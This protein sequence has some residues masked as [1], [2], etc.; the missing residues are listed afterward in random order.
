MSK[1]IGTLPNQVPSNADLGSAA[2]KQVEE[3]LSA[4]GS[5]LSAIDSTILRTA[6]DFFIYN[7]ANDSDGGEWRK[8]CQDKSWYKRAGE[9]GWLGD[10][11][12]RPDFPSVAILI[13]DTAGLYIY[14]ADTPDLPLWMS[15]S[16]NSRGPIYEVPTCVSALSGIIY[17]GGNNGASSSF[18][19]EISF[20][21]DTMRLH[22]DG[23]KN[24]ARDS[25]INTI[26][27]YGEG[28]GWISQAPAISISNDYQ[29]PDRKTNAIATAYYPNSPIDQRTGLIRPT[30]AVAMDNAFSVINADGSITTAVNEEYHHFT[31]VDWLTHNKIFAGTAHISG[32]VG[33]RQFV[34]DYDGTTCSTR[35]QEGWTQDTTGVNWSTGYRSG[36]G[37][38]LD[39]RRCASDGKGRQ[40]IGHAGLTVYNGLTMVD[41]N[42]SDEDSMAA[43]VK[44]DYNTGWMPGDIKVATLA[45]TKQGYIDTSNQLPNWNT[46]GWTAQSSINVTGGTNLTIT[47]NGTGSNVYFYTPI[48]VEPY[49]DYVIHM[50]F[51]NSYT[52]PGWYVN[53]TAYST[54]GQLANIGNED[55]VLEFFSGNRTTVYLQSYQVSTNATVVT[56]INVMKA[57]RDHTAWGNGLVREGTLRRVPVSSGAELCGYEGFDSN[58][59]GSYIWQ[60]YNSELNFGTGDWC[61]LG[62]VNT[63]RTSGYADLISRG[64]AGDVGWSSSNASSWFLQMYGTGGQSVPQRALNLY[65]KSGGTLDGTGWTS[66]VLPYGRWAHVAM[67]K[68]GTKMRIYIDG[69]QGV[70]GDIGS[71][72]FSLPDEV[73]S[74]LRIGWQGPNYNF[75]SSYEKL[76]L[77]RVSGTVPSMD[78]LHKM[79][80]DERELFKEDAKATLYGDSDAVL[81]AGYDKGTDLLHVGTEDGRSVFNGL[82]RVDENPDSPIFVAIEANNG[83]ILEE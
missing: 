75:P 13:I 32:V 1:L 59:G 26:V 80:A 68:T 48:S 67:I 71:L 61:I 44:H 18:L 6:T 72:S 29:M 81:G 23:G 11:N 28:S 60:D 3:F 69:E 7:T 77:W 9:Y 37:D 82:T 24:Q 35:T 15:F 63:T 33:I 76:A 2:Y 43:Y 53:S 17:V 70:E 16:R 64:N 65:V 40:F 34:F 62:W 46:S 58:N 19:S 74:S 55:G 66:N 21:H 14:D 12:S 49:T 56:N 8:H 54:S 57:E 52:T 39:K 20:V 27:P 83:L 36:S 30:I 10:N 42:T 4:R 78:Q 45:D 50:E 47:G 51:S 79:I 25:W 73:S 31:S 38:F 41:Y 5:S 22:Q